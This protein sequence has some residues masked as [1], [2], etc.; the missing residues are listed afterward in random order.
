MELQEGDT[1]T[2]FVVVN[3]QNKPQAKDVIL[4]QRN[5]IPN[6]N[7]KRV[8]YDEQ[9]RMIAQNGGMFP[10]NS[11]DGGM[12]RTTTVSSTQQ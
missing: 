8:D 12:N 3:P 7:A 10:T 2:L 5:Q 6:P 9:R 4:I 11:G 1:V